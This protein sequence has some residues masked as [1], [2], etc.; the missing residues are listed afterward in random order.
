MVIASLMERRAPG[1]GPSKFPVVAKD[2]SHFWF[3]WLLSIQQPKKVSISTPGI[4][5]IDCTLG[6]SSGCVAMLTGTYVLV[7]ALKFT[8]G[9]A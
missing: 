7:V 3:G 8:R 5:V 9:D 4:T 1:K 6:L 2:G